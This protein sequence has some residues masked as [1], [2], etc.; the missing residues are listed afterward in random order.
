MNRTSRFLKKP[1]ILIKVLI[2]S[3]TFCELLFAEPHHRRLVNPVLAP[4]YQRLE[5]TPPLAGSYELP[6]LGSA[7]DAELIDSQGRK[8]RLHQLMKDK[9]TVL[10]FIYTS[11]SDVNGCPLSSY[12]MSKVQRRLMSDVILKDKVQLVSF[13][14]DPRNDTPQVLDKYGLNFKQ[15]GFDWHFVTTESDEQLAAILEDYNQFVIRDNE[16]KGNPAGSISHL[17]RVYLIDRNRAIR[18][19]YSV[20]FLHPDTVMNDILT[21]VL[22]AKTQR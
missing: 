15:P 8:I 21:I 20:A 9:V 3:M 16:S 7:A 18:N 2:V 1:L 10:S 11:C 6:L 17:L 22:E 5:F 12:V 19:I 13:S 4:G 14:F